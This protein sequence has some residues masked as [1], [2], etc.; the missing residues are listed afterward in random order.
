VGSI[1]DLQRTPV[2]IQNLNA[3]QDQD[4][5]VT[6]AALLQA[7]VLVMVESGL[8][9]NLVRVLLDSYAGWPIPSLTPRLLQ[10][11]PQEIAARV[12]LF[13][14]HVVLY[15]A[16]LL[17]PL[18]MVEAAFAMLGQ[19]SPQLQVSSL[20]SPIK[21]LVGMTVLLLYWASLSQH[22]AGDFARQLDLIAALYGAR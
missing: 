8:F 14:T 18:L 2:Q 21:C 6:G 19:A 7:G 16:P 9:L 4:A 13:M 11:P 1:Y 17:M 12:G 5:S 22:V 10:M 20:A 15:T 3:S